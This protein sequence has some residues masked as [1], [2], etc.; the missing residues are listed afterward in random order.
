MGISRE[1]SN[2]IRRAVKHFEDNLH[3]F[4]LVAE[5][6]HRYFL[7]DKVLSSLV[8]SMKYRVKDP[9]HLKDK[10]RRKALNAIAKGE[11]PEVRH[12]NLFEKVSD[13]A[14]V[15]LLHLH[16]HQIEKIIPEILRVLEEN[17]C[18]VVEGPFAYTWDDETRALLT[19]IGLETEYKPELYTSIH[20]VVELN[21]KAHWQCEI[22]IRTLME[23]VWGEVSHIVNYPHP[24]KS[25][26]CAEQLKVLAR[27]ASGATRLVDS[28]FASCDEYAK[29]LS[30]K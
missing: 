6:V 24:T 4:E 21:T 29:M 20:L 25:V 17:N 19:S 5:T 3:H 14:G 9:T 13:L 26:A 18:P 30:K 16:P 1:E 23:E 7:K 8:H 22:Q 2:K 28:I 10:L 15:R 12:D 27:V 11:V